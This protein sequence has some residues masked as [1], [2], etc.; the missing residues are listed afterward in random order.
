MTRHLHLPHPHI[1]DRF[2][3]HVGKGFWGGMFHHSRPAPI[4]PDG[5]DWTGWHYPDGEGY[6]YNPCDQGHRW[7]ADANTRPGT[8]VQCAVCGTATV[9]VGE[10]A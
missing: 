8:W 4:V 7:L 6:A 2:I 10:V 9:W 3:E 1:A 5:H